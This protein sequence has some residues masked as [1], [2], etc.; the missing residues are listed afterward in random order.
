[1]V[2]GLDIFKTYFEQYPNNYVIIGGS[3]CDVIIES[4]GFTPRATKD[5]DIIL[6]VEALN[7]DFVRQFWQFIQDGDYERK[8]RSADERKY[9]RFM[10]PQK[11]GFPFQIELFSRNPDLI[12]IP[13]GP[14]LTPIPV[15]DDLSS[16][17]AI[18]LNDDYYNF[19]IGHS[20]L[21]DNLHY[22][23]TEALICLKAKA[24]LEIADRIDKGSKE[25]SKQLRKH[26]GDIFRLAVMLKEEDIFD[27]PPSLQ[28]NLVEFTKA[29]ASDLPDKSLFK[30]MGLGGISVER[31]YNQLLKSFKIID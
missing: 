23:N 4:A 7:A 24:Y 12:D 8:E 29:I 10:K 28:R 25:D 20:V 30:E 18:L 11:T 17:S 21:T 31:V 27:L 22:A 16:L 19:M 15:D 9:Y 5:I 6:V 13:E 14:H 26:K 1:M 2:R 3:A